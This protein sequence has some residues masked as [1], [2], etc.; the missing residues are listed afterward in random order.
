MQ[1][2]LAHVSGTGGAGIASLHPQHTLHTAEPP[3]V[4][5]PQNCHL[6]ADQRGRGQALVRVADVHALREASLRPYCQWTTITRDE[7]TT[8][9]ESG[10]NSF[11]SSEH[12][13][14]S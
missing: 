1:V 14:S 13:R 4:R 2:L 7:D 6:R 3:H 12:A 8:D 11:Q 10:V 9:T 5:V